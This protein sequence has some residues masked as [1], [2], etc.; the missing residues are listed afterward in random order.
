MAGPPPPNQAPVQAAGK[1]GE[2]PGGL[3]LGAGAPLPLGQWGGGVG[4]LRGPG[5]GL[6]SPQCEWPII[7]PKGWELRVSLC[8]LGKAPLGDNHP[9]R[10]VE[11]VIRVF[12]GDQASSENSGHSSSGLPLSPAAWDPV[13]HPWGGG[14]GRTMSVT[15]L[16]AQPP[17]HHCGLLAGGSLVLGARRWGV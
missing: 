5:V 9:G 10:E 4:R 16:G 8:P 3:Q 1:V 14:E 13:A 7:L 6:G 12:K 11:V 2:G 15:E 17:P